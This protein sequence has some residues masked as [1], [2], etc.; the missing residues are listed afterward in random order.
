MQII[1]QLVYKQVQNYEGKTE[2]TKVWGKN[3]VA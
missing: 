1:I 3:L 2:V